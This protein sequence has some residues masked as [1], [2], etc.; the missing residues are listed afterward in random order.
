[1]ILEQKRRK[2]LEELGYS[3]F[4]TGEIYIDSK[5]AAKQMFDNRDA[6][7]NIRKIC[8]GEYGYR[9]YKGYTFEFV[10]IEEEA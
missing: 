4:E 2:I 3:N 7:R 5:T 10:D 6:A 1:M 9:S 8:S